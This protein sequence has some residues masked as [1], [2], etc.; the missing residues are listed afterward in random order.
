MIIAQWATSLVMTGLGVSIAV[1]GRRVPSRSRT[2]LR[3]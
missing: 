2:G 1:T 3:R